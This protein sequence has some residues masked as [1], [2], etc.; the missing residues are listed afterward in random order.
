[1]DNEANNKSNEIRESKH[2]ALL[3]KIRVR[4]K[5]E[6]ELIQLPVLAR[7][8]GVKQATLYLHAREGHLF[9]PCLYINKTP[10]VRLDDLVEWMLDNGNPTRNQSV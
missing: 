7:I 9:L 8:V 6:S 10:L 1:M 5:L 2:Q 3:T 4:F